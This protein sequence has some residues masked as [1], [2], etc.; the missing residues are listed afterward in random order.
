[1]AEAHLV[2]NVKKS[3]IGIDLEKEK[4]KTI[5]LLLFKN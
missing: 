1:M 2:K 3:I 4:K 5:K